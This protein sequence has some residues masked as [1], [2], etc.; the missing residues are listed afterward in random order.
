MTVQLLRIEAAAEKLDLPAKSLRDVAE[1]HGLLIRVGRALRLHPEDLEMLIEL[2]R[3][4]AKVSVSTPAPATAENS[5]S[6]TVRPS[7][8]QARQIA[9]R[10]KRCSPPISS[11]AS[12]QVVPLNQTG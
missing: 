3:V 1:E 6:S 12:G 10:L 8:G 4:P 2:C 5:S 9:D 11:S 7:V